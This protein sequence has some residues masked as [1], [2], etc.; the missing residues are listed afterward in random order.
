MIEGVVAGYPVVDVR[1]R[2][3]FGGYHDVDSSEMAF[4]I[5]GLNAFRKAVQEAKPVLLEPVMQ[6]QIEVPEDYTGGVMGDL[7]SRR[8]K[9]LGMEPGG[10]KSQI[11]KAT[12]PQGELHRYSTTLRTLTQ[13]RA[14]Y[15]TEF[16]HYE[17]VPREI[18]EKLAEELRKEREAA[19]S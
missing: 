18:A 1:V 7:S 8:G 2:L 4:K 12:V 5:A 9:I 6:V 16:S 3:H 15:Q 13:G 10:G 11:I 17:E 14:R 19:A